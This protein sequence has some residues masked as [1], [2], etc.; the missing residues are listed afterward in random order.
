MKPFYITCGICEH[1]FQD[2]ALGKNLNSWNPARRLPAKSR[3]KSAEA[4]HEYHESKCSHCV[5]HS[6]R[7][8]DYADAIKTE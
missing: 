8:R 5:C 2:N 3:I 7:P 6:C 4:F 1:T